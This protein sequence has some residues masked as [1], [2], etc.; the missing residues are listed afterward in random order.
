MARFYLADWR[1]AKEDSSV[2]ERERSGCSFPTACREVTAS[3]LKQAGGGCGH[4]QQQQRRRQS[5]GKRQGSGRG[6]DGLSRNGTLFLR[7]QLGLGS[8]VGY[9]LVS[10]VKRELVLQAPGEDRHGQHEQSEGEQENKT[11]FSRRIKAAPH[12]SLDAFS[13]IFVVFVSHLSG[14]SR[15][16]SPG[17]GTGRA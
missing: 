11:A 2:T 14:F 12:E 10:F 9:R 4:C 6:V 5:S 8:N 7:E 1:R 16:L 13:Q 3:R 17:V 15:S